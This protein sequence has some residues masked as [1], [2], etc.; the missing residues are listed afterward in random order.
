MS[1]TGSDEIYVLGKSEKTECN[2]QTLRQE[3]A[4]VRLVQGVLCWV[5]HP[6]EEAYKQ[7]HFL[8]GYV[9]SGFLEDIPRLLRN[10]CF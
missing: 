3:N 1:L 10:C 7:E 5:Q 8:L 9:I 6:V 2:F 4:G